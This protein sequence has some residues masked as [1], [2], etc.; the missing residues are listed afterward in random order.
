MVY[1]RPRGLGGGEEEGQEKDADDADILSYQVW[2][3]GYQLCCLISTRIA[4]FV[5]LIWAWKQGLKQ[6][7]KHELVIHLL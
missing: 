3:Q 6:V 5:N 7:F 1:Y 2:Q 4:C